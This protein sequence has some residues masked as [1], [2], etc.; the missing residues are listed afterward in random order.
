MAPPVEIA[1]EALQ[2]SCGG[3]HAAGEEVEALLQAPQTGTDDAGM[4]RGK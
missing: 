4:K 3:P 2:E 1:W